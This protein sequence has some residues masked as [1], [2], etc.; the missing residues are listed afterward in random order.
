MPRPKHKNNKVNVTPERML[1]NLYKE[2]DSLQ[3]VLAGVSIGNGESCSTTVFSSLRALLATGSRNMRPLL[4]SALQ[5]FNISP[6]IYSSPIADPKK[7]AIIIYLGKNWSGF[8]HS[9]NLNLVSLKEYM[10]EE[11]YFDLYTDEKVS[12]NLLLRK[13]ADQEGSHFD[14][15]VEKYIYL[16][17]ENSASINDEKVTQKELFMWNLYMLIDYHINYIHREL[18]F[19]EAYSLNS[20]LETMHNW[21]KEL[22]K[23]RSHYDKSLSGLSGFHMI[24]INRTCESCSSDLNKI[25]DIEFKCSE[26]DLILE[27]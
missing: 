8:Q 17:E 25:S 23:I 24:E 19:R 26:C 16:M 14:E 1:K 9:D 4:H 10:N 27:L 6:P 11:A 12:R 3:K 13:F 20:N 15:S 21:T 5:S 7:T 22:H 2:Q 18:H